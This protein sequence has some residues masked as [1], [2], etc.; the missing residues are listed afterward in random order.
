MVDKHN[1]R[2]HYILIKISNILPKL[3][4]TVKRHIGCCLGVASFWSLRCLGQIRFETRLL[5]NGLAPIWRQSISWKN[6]ELQYITTTWLLN[7]HWFIEQGFVMIASRNGLTRTRRQTIFLN[8][9]L[10]TY[11]WFFLYGIFLSTKEFLRPY[12][13]FLNYY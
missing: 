1:Y 3:W 10:E 12:T 13:L 2:C 4:I 8:Q 11:T 7:L 9:F 5:I 6:I